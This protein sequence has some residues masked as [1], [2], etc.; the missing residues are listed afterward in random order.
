MQVLQN[1]LPKNILNKVF[2]AHKKISN[3]YL[4]ENKGNYDTYYNIELKLNLLEFSLI[5]K[6]IYY[7][8]VNKLK[9]NLLYNIIVI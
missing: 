8:A 1:L 6:I 5:K 7:F 4:H 3:M 9:N 2:N